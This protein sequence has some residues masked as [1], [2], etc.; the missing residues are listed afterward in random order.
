MSKKAGLFLVAF[1]FLFAAIAS[2]APPAKLFIPDENFP[3]YVAEPDGNAQSGARVCKDSSGNVVVAWIEDGDVYVQKIDTDA[4][5]LWEPKDTGVKALEGN[6]TAVRVAC[7]G[8]DVLIAAINNADEIILQRLDAN[9]NTQWD[10]P[11]KKIVGTDADMDDA[12]EICCDGAGGLFI[13]WGVDA[14]EQVKARR[15]DIETGNFSYDAK[16]ILDEDDEELDETEDVPSTIDDAATLSGIG[17]APTGAGGVWVV[18]WYDT[19]TIDGDNSP[20]TCWVTRA[21]GTGGELEPAAGSEPYT[22]FSDDTNTADTEKLI[23]FSDGDK[24]VVCV[25]LWTDGTSHYVTIDGRTKNAEDYAQNNIAQNGNVDLYDA[26][27]M[28]VSDELAVLW[29]DD[30]TGNDAYKLQRY[31]IDHVEKEFTEVWETNPFDVDAAKVDEGV[32]LDSDDDAETAKIADLGGGYV[33]YSWIEGGAGT[34]DHDLFAM[35]VDPDGNA[36]FNDADTPV[37]I[38]AG[39]GDEITENVAMLA[40]SAF[41]IA[42]FDPDGVDNETYRVGHFD[43][44]LRPDLRWITDI[45][46]TGELDTDKDT[47]TITIDDGV[48]ENAG[49]ADVTD[50]IFVDLY[51]VR[52]DD[53]VFDSW[54]DWNDA[55][56]VLIYDDLN[57]GPLAVGETYSFADNNLEISIDKETLNSAL[58]QLGEGYEAGDEY[59]IVGIVNPGNTIDEGEYYKPNGNAKNISSEEISEADIHAPDLIPNAI[60]TNV[61]LAGV[62][63]GQAV[64]L[65]GVE[66]KNQG[67]RDGTSVSFYLWP[68]NVV[69]LNIDDLKENGT[70]LGKVEDVTVEAGQIVTLD[71]VELTIPGTTPTGGYV[72]YAVPDA[73]GEV[74]EFSGYGVKPEGNNLNTGTGVGRTNEFHVTGYPDL[75]VYMAILSTDTANP[76]DSVD[77]QYI[78]KNQ[79]AEPA[80][81]SIA[82]I[83]FSDDENLD[84]GDTRLNWRLTEALGAGHYTEV[85]EDTVTIPDVAAGNYY[86]LVVTDDTGLVTEGDETNNVYALP[87][88]VSPPVVLDITAT[89]TGGNLVVKA[90]I[91]DAGDYAGQTGTFAIWG[92]HPTLGCYTFYWVN[93][94]LPCEEGTQPHKFSFTINV[95]GPYTVL[96]MPAAFLPTG[97]YTFHLAVDVDNDGTWDAEDTCTWTN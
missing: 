36:V 14:Q 49:Q 7:C 15:I 95:G 89:T 5:R 21:V 59:Y 51:L 4:N 79:G 26:C 38:E 70:F 31:T 47:N 44:Q 41:C 39:A 96:T 2:A 17:I 58:Q 28:S 40:G 29:T 84:D 32:A 20:D 19:P 76:G 35:V 52:D 65:D 77:Y 9:G 6:Y 71:P 64:T 68:S 54:D 62:L 93:Y 13:A 27:Y 80:D 91:S 30:N 10:G 72:I 22:I 92:T 11:P 88:T 73:D 85:Y 46:Y 87:I 37:V 12:L 63:A 67:D 82:A 66:I 23:V 78:I 56:K 94:W 45:A 50:D 25:G 33:G 57:I 61:A 48:I 83:Y 24:G 18:G 74:G 86:I 42:N 16:V 53:G 8:D 97:E 43:W 34:V 75:I 69:L 90:A 81:P 1:F 55:T 60:D 3:R